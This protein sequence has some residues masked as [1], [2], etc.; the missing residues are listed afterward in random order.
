MD[1]WEY[2]ELY[3]GGLPGPVH[4]PKNMDISIL[5]AIGIGGLVQY[6]RHSLTAMGGVGD[7]DSHLSEIVMGP[8]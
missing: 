1:H 7:D 5:Y 2:P 8:W 6:T 3:C 4:T